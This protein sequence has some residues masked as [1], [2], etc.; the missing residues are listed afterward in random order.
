MTN[1]TNKSW[2]DL[3]NLIQKVFI[4]QNRELNQIKYVTEKTNFFYNLLMNLEKKQQIDENTIILEDEQ[5]KEEYISYYNNLTNAICIFK[6]KPLNLNDTQIKEMIWQESK[7]YFITLN[8]NLLRIDILNSYIDTDM[9]TSIYNLNDLSLKNN[10]NTLWEL[11]SSHEFQNNATSVW[12]I[13]SELRANINGEPKC[14][15][16][17]SIQNNEKHLI[18]HA[19]LDKQKN[20]ALDPFNNHENVVQ[21]AIKLQEKTR[22][23]KLEQ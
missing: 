17:Y 8:N 11:I 22:A 19:S 4:E 20:I 14:Q 5:T 16:I 18:L 23:L 15:T 9:I 1:T 7:Q 21:T 2:Q 10:Y 3:N 13:I 6:N 12:T